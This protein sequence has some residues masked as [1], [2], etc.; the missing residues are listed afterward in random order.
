MPKRLSLPDDKYKRNLVARIEYHCT[1]RG[2]TR[3]HQRIIVRC[4][5]ATMC[6]RLSDPG[7]FTLDELIR[8][9]NELKIPVWELL[10]PHD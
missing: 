4:S 3:E 1:I 5:P 7:T 9:A 10:K 8:L 6:R 2:I